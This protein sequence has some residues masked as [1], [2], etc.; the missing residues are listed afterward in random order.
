M[1]QR[2]IRVCRVRKNNDPHVE[3]SWTGVG[4]PLSIKNPTPLYFNFETFHQ[5][6]LVF[7]VN[8]QSGE[9]VESGQFEM[10]YRHK[11]SNKNLPIHLRRY[12]RNIY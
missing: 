2:W 1:N 12:H 8:L 3:R 11:P 9:R 10:P 4:R 6:A 5:R 7:F